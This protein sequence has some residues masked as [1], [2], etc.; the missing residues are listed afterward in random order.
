[1][2]SYEKIYLKGATL[3]GTASEGTFGRFKRLATTLLEL[4]AV[5][6]EVA[7]CGCYRGLSTFIIA[8]YLWLTDQKFTGVGMH[9]IDS[10]EGLGDPVSKDYGT[11]DE[12]VQINKMMVKGAFSAPIDVVK[13]ATKEYPN[14]AFYPGWIPEIF[15]QIPETRFKLVHIDVDLY[16][17]TLASLEYFFPRLVPGGI[18]ICDDVNWPGARRALE[19]FEDTH[20]A[21]I[22]VTSE[23]ATFIRRK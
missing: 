2:T 19:E 11:A 18:I 20:G 3:S 8:S 1:M 5:E 23:M 21:D 22:S 9:V 16:S 4:Q 13:Y 7:E 14:I 10:F 15:A 12:M 6:G 17:P